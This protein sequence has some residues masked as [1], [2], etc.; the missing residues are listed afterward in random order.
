LIVMYFTGLNL[1]WQYFAFHHKKESKLLNF[2]FIRKFNIP[3]WM[4][5]YANQ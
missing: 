4:T 3:F 1:N 2:T 5:I